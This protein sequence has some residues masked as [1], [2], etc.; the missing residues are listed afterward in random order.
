MQYF[1]QDFLDFYSELDK[2]NNKIWFDDNRKRYEKSVKEPFMNFVQELINELSK[3]DFDIIIKPADAIFRINR[4]IRF[5]LDKTPYKTQ[6]S[7]IISRFGKKNK[8]YPGYYF[9]LSADNIMIYGGV[10]FAE[11]EILE[12][13]RY[14]IAENLDEFQ[15]LYKNENFIEKYKELQGEKNKRIPSD[16]IDIVKIEPLIANKQFYFGAELDSKLILSSDLLEIL[17]QYFESGREMSN[18]FKRA[19]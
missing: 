6:S 10:Y 5:S 3:I 19:F 1:T 9:E 13:I 12:K 14:S 2:N 16:F 4:D 8:S 15:S 11:K 17:L 18:F 7:A